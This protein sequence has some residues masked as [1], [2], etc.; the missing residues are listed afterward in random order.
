MLI[1]GLKLLWLAFTIMCACYLTRTVVHR[2]F[3][4]E[5]L[6]NGNR[7]HDTSVGT[8]DIQLNQHIAGH[9]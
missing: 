4:R 2:V 5:L 1:A 3:W 7:L 9:H 6:Q 8:L